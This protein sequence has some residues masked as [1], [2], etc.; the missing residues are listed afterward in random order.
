[1][2]IPHRRVAEDLR[3]ATRVSHHFRPSQIATENCQQQNL[4][5]E[6]S[7]HNESMI[8][9][10]FLSQSSLLI[11]TLVEKRLYLFQAGGGIGLGALVCSHNRVHLLKTSL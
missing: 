4:S 3:A 2:P 9:F 7:A 6:K 11:R 1:M 5:N 10:T 8:S